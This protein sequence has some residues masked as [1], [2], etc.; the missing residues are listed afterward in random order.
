MSFELSANP[1]HVSHRADP[2]A[3]GS[4]VYAVNTLAAYK[5]SIFLPFLIAAALKTA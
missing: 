2:I 5:L 1:Y 4:A 3:R